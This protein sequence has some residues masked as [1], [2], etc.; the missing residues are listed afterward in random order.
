MGDDENIKVRRIVDESARGGCG[1]N[2][3]GF[4]AA[5]KKRPTS[6]TK[7][8]FHGTFVLTTFERA[9]SIPLVL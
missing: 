5:N 2:S 8:R 7:P 6:V 4:V 3:R 1:P 9:L